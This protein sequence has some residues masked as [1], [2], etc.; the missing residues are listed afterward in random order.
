ANRLGRPEWINAEAKVPQPLHLI[1]WEDKHP[2]DV[3]YVLYHYAKPDDKHPEHPLDTLGKLRWTIVSQPN[4]DQGE[5]KVVFSTG[6][7]FKDLAITKTYTLAPEDY[8]V[9]LTVAI[10]RTS[11]GSEPL[12]FRYQLT[13]AEGMPVEGEWYTTT[14]R[15]SMIG[16][17]SNK[18][19][20]DR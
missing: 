15:T 9:G 12:S 7:F 2:T 17:V 18:G 5:Q 13:G 20:V 16:L 1:P 8:H 14:Y 19:L 11:T 10:E 4:G 3:S 6:K